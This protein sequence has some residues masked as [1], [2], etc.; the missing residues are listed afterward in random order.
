M[1]AKELLEEAKA[2]GVSLQLRPDETIAAHF[3]EEIAGER[4]DRLTQA[5]RRHKPEIVRE[6]LPE[7]VERFLPREKCRRR[8]NGFWSRCFDAKTRLIDWAESTGIIPTPKEAFQLFPAHDRTVIRWAIASLGLVCP[9]CVLLGGVIACTHDKPATWFPRPD[10]AKEI[11]DW[12]LD[13]LTGHLLA[14]DAEIVRAAS[15]AGFPRIRLERNQTPKT[16]GEPCKQ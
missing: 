6:M 11:R 13:Y 14:T 10:P 2:A 15:R 5:L 16:K 4:R 3:P 1:G 8:G 7:E 9:K 12:I